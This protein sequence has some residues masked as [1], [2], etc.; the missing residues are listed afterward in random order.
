MIRSILSAVVIATLATGVFAKDSKELEAAKKEYA[1]NVAK[2]PEG[3][4]VKLVSTLAKKMGEWAH[5]FHETGSRKHGDDLQAYSQEAGKHP[6]PKDSDGKKFAATL[7][8]KWQTTRHD[9]EFRKNGIYVMLPEDADT[10]KDKWRI[11]GNQF[12]QKQGDVESRYTIV[13]LDKDYFIYG[14]KEGTFIMTRVK[15]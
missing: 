10:P 2:D 9:F 15:K 11:E 1:Q 4:R 5:E 13:L 6:A 7:L 12:I 8:G 14:D 3:A